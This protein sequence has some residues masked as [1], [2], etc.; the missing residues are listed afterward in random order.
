MTEQQMEEQQLCDCC[1]EVVENP[2]RAE[3]GEE[4]C[5]LCWEEDLRDPKANVVANGFPHG[6]SIGHYRNRTKEEFGEDHFTAEWHSTDAWRGY[7]SVEA[8]GDWEKVDEDQVLTSW[9]D[10]ELKEKY[11]RLKDLA[12][13]AGL[14]WALVSARTSNVFSNS[15][16]FYVLGDP[17]ELD[18]AAEA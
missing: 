11:D 4:I 1:E 6:L 10:A 14:E 8:H 16:E 15:A 7:Y 13:E 17:S 9:N 12:D 3:G 5:E 2:L 18:R